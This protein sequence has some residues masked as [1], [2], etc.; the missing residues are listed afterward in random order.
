MKQSSL[1]V[2]FI[3]AI[4]ATGG[5]LFGYDTGVISGALLFIRAEWNLSEASQEWVV[6]AVLIGA[7]AGALLS[8]KLT[9]IL[10]RKKVNLI[11]AIIFTLGAVGT[12]LAPTADWLVAGRIIIGIAVGI[13]SFTVPLYI[14]EISPSRIRGALVSLNQLAITIGIVASYVCGYLFSSHEYGW[15][16]M[17]LMG[18]IPALI[19]G[20]GMIFLPESPR[21]LM[22]R[23]REAEA[24][25]VLERISPDEDI[26]KELRMM[27]ENIENEKGGDWRELFSSRLRQPLLI[28]IGIFFFQQFSGINAVIYYA[29]HIFNI[30][31]FQSADASIL[32]TTGVGIINVLFTIL[33]LRLLD[34]WGRK[35]LLY[36]GFMGIIFSLGTLALAFHYSEAFGESLKWI[37]VGSLLSYIAFFAISLGPMGW[38]LIS[39]IYPLKIRGFAMSLGSF[40]HW[41]FNFIISFTFLSMITALSPAGAF[42]LFALISAA[43]F[44]FAKF[45]IPETKGVSLEEIEAAWGKKERVGERA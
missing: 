35:P 5:L 9:D 2:Y 16:L 40:Y 42:C 20:I 4:A 13:A 45:Y 24:R 33:S 39:E 38:L 41:I 22:T 17:F 7:I 36:M 23:K 6:S 21:W 1:Q 43:G 25:K 29:P 3:A 37:A 32:A 18:F 34:R 14:S 30:S 44:V 11:T 28:G 15:R 19:L 27:K 26:D 8:G 12:G 10:G 31:G